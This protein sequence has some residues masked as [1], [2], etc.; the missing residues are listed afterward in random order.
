MTNAHGAYVA[1]TYQDA[2][3]RVS[4][5]M[6][7]A[8]TP[9][10]VGIDGRSGS[11]KTTFAQQL[12]TELAPLAVE[13]VEVEDFIGGWHGLSR[14]IGRV[15]HI[16]SELQA[17]GEATATPWDWYAGEWAEPI[18]LPHSKQID[19]A[20][21]VGCGSTSKLVRPHLD[22]TVW[23]EVDEN[24]RRKR[25]EERDPYDWSDYW[26]VWARQEEELLAE[27]P[28]DREADIIVQQ[29]P[30]TSSLREVCPARQ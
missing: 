20:L 16:V 7:D 28:S 1:R 8:S 25:V 3:A 30:E 26:Q 27:F 15:A 11:G 24:I 29:R 18:Q 22:A 12:A 5:L 14:D 6:T 2:F 19:A 17:S 10:L 13:C 23:I 4:E 21:I 9:V